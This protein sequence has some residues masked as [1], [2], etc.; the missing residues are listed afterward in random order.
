M[1]EFSVIIPTYNRA[2]TLG[3]AIESLLNQTLP[4]LEIIVVDDGSNDDTGEMIKIYSEVRYFF[5][6]NQGVSA[7]RNLGA[8]EAKGDWL[9]FLD[10]DDELTHTALSVFYAEIQRNPKVELFIAGRDRKTIKGSEI[11][12]PK[13][14]VYTPMLSGTFCLRSTIFQKA[15]GYDDRFTFAENTEL[16]HRIGQ[17]GIIRHLIPEVSLIYYDSFSGGSKNIENIIS[18]GSLF[19]T[20]HQTTLSES[21][22]FLYYQIVGVNQLRFQRFDEARINLWK[23]YILR[24]TKLKTLARLVLSYI[25]IIS[26]MFYTRQTNL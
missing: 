13:E 1:P 20:K 4:P 11:R 2:S 9:I 18:S 25:P 24:P 12:I 17:L 10:S 16:F 3:R 15:G 5:Q 19:L 8:G 22:R 26:K 23:A 6:E 7:A 14:G 21:D